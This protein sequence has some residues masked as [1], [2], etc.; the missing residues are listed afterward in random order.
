[1]FLNDRHT[2]LKMAFY[3]R[4]WTFQHFTYSYPQ[5]ENGVTK[6]EKL[7]EII[8]LAEKLS[9]GFDIVRADFYILNDG[10][11]K[12]GEMTFASAG[13]FCKWNPKEYNRLLGKEITLSKDGAG[14][15]T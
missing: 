14:G 8:I 4:N 12:F 11:I 6:P 7:D 3:D 9:L 2:A 5:M 1:M 15:R 13:G 10:S